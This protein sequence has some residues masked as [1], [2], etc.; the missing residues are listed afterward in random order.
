MWS[1]SL[2]PFRLLRPAVHRASKL[3]VNIVEPVHK[4]HYSKRS[5][6][7]RSLEMSTPLAAVSRCSYIMYS[8]RNKKRT[9]THKVTHTHTHGATCGAIVQ[10]QMTGGDATRHIDNDD[11]LNRAHAS[12]SALRTR[13]LQMSDDPCRRVRTSRLPITISA[14]CCVLLLHAQP[15]IGVVNSFR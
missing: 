8:V 7:V 6:R 15:L 9:V 3:P 10:M 12:N 14:Y 11:A 1:S 5:G 4:R 2:I 13:R